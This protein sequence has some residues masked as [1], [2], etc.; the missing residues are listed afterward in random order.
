EN[1]AEA[2]W[3]TPKRYGIEDRILAFMLDNASNND[4]LVDGVQSRAAKEG[5]Y[6]DAAWARLRCMPHTI[7][8]AAI[9][10]LE[11]IGAISKT[12]AKKA[13]SRSGNYQD[14]T[15]APLS[16]DH[17]DDAAA[18]ED[19]DEDAGISFSLDKSANILPAVEK[20][21]HNYLYA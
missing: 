20:V 2:V 12:E 9:K 3:E 1:M 17:D 8:L 10:L 15:T 11:A 5:I 19:T 7:H 14:S 6:F 13:A 18:R 21:S 4:T 16:R